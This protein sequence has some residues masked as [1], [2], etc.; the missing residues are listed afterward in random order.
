[1]AAHGELEINISVLFVHAASLYFAIKTLLGQHREIKHRRDLDSSKK[2]DLFMPMP[3]VRRAQ[4]ASKH[5]TTR[6]AMDQ[7]PVQI[8]NA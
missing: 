6:T 2:Q 8:S 3:V 5:M 1:M 7:C 4:S